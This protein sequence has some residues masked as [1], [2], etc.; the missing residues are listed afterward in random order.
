MFLPKNDKILS[1]FNTKP[2]RRVVEINIEFNVSGILD[3]LKS[4]GKPED[5]DKIDRNWGNAITQKYVIDMMPIGKTSN[6]YYHRSKGLVSQRLE[7][8]DYLSKA[9]EDLKFHAKKQGLET[10]EW[11]IWKGCLLLMVQVNG[12][13]NIISA[14]PVLTEV[15]ELETKGKID[16]IGNLRDDDIKMT[17]AISVDDEGK[18]KDSIDTWKWYGFLGNSA[19]GYKNGLGGVSFSIPLFDVEY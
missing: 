18:T 12:K 8:T 15:V 5:I 6:A 14:T 1:M 10:F 17:V 9:D 11:K 13:R 7:G 19:V 2:D 3:W 4:G 16:N